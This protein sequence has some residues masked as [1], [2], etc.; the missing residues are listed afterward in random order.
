MPLFFKTKLLKVLFHL[1]FFR[2]MFFFYRKTIPILMIH[3]VVDDR[4]HH[5]WTPGWKRLSTQQ[6]DNGLKIFSRYF[7][8]ITFD[9]AI[10]M[11][12]SK[13]R[14]EPYSIVLTFDDGY[15]NNLAHAH[16]VTNLYKAPS[17]YF[18][19]PE[20]CKKNSPYWIDRLDYALQFSGEKSIN[21][22]IGALS[23][24]VEIQNRSQYIVDLQKLRLKMKETYTNDIVL[25]AHLN[26]FLNQIESKSGNSIE[27][28][29]SN[30]DLSRMLSEQEI[31][32]LPYDIEVGSHSN[33]HLRLV[34]LDQD[35]LI[36]EIT[37]SK[38]ALESLTKKT[39]LHFCY[40]NGN[41]STR[42]AKAIK[43]AG[44]TS[45]STTE[46]GTNKPGDD[47]F[48]IK[49]ISFPDP[50]SPAQLLGQF[51]NHLRTRQR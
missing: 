47:L 28:I 19:A 26:I 24:I 9:D 25:M 12:A 3:G 11:L 5:T 39:C 2:I 45:A 7:N 21:V 51:F 46:S 37:D 36:S 23:Q 38:K 32:N 17:I 41:H 14:L 44:Y 34:H 42:T 43:S 16:P 8:F 35:Q 33:N 18:I 49:R 30:D 1:G 4:D 13:K 40:P 31:S 29:K 48:K 50:Q 15:Y 6:L 27:N 22:V 20:P 10:L